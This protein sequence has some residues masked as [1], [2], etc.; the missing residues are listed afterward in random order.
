MI[1]VLLDKEASERRIDRLILHIKIKMD[2]LLNEY[3]RIPEMI[4][5]DDFIDEYL[6][7]FTNAIEEYSQGELNNTDYFYVKALEIMKDFFYEEGCPKI[8]DSKKVA[9]FL[10]QT[11]ISPLL[12]AN[13]EVRNNFEIIQQ[14]I[15]FTE[16][17]ANDDLD[18]IYKDD[19]DFVKGWIAFYPRAY[20][21]LN[22]SL[23]DDFELLK[24]ASGKAPDLIMYTSERIRSNRDLMQELVEESPYAILFMKDEFKNDVDLIKAAIEKDP[25][26]YRFLNLDLKD[27][28]D[29][30]KY[31]K[32]RVA[33][34]PFAYKVLVDPLPQPVFIKK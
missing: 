25:G 18:S 1:G 11:G 19:R 27:N 16:G 12:F 20:Q 8:S 24:L 2:D 4:F 23:R 22:K 9:N 3:G 34:Y 14:A 21:F 28:D 6:E 30:K 33:K 17:R 26:V 29:I 13:D 31:H 15:T 5:T 10:Y 32:E 7:V